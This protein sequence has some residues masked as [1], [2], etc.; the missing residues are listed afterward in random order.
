[1]GEKIY[2]K[3]IRDRIPEIIKKSGKEY[4][5]RVLED[6]EYIE[7]LDNKLIEELND[8]EES[9]EMEELA[10][11]LEVIFAVCEARG[12]SIQELESIRKEKAEKRGSFKEKLLLKRVIE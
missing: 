1:M 7:Y 2:N 8:Y 12:I 11:I 5:I 9:K 6:D 4:E 10:D 3:L